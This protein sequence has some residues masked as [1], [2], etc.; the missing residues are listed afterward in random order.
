MSPLLNTRTD[1]LAAGL[2]VGLAAVGTAA[3]ILYKRSSVKKYVDDPSHVGC[4]VSTPMA[5]TPTYDI[6]IIG[7]CCSLH[8]P[9]LLPNVFLSQAEERLDVLWPPA[10]RRTQILAFS[11]LKQEG[12]R[13]FSTVGSGWD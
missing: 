3:T 7:N 4:L 13:Y 5:H 12:G 2:A 10:F 9:L 6:V 1:L 11:Y 8:T